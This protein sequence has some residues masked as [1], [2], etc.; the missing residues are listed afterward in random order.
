MASRL[1]R[2]SLEDLDFLPPLKRARVAR[3]SFW[4]SSWLTSFLGSLR[5]PRPR[6]SPRPAWLPA[7]LTSTFLTR[8][9]FRLPSSPVVFFFST[10]NSILPTTVGPDSF[11]ARAR[12]TSDSAGLAGALASGS[13]FAAG[14][15]SAGLAAGFS[16]AGVSSFLAVFLAGFLGFNASK[17]TVPTTLGP[18]WVGVASSAAAAGFAASDAGAAS[19]LAAGAGASAGDSSFAGVA[20]G[21]GA[22]WVRFTTGAASL[23]RNWLKSISGSSSSFFTSRFRALASVMLSRSW[24]PVALRWAFCLVSLSPWKLDFTSA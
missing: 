7:L 13:A 24:M 4:M 16:S 22:G 14:C 20:S 10:G 19:S 6:W 8:T 21:A 9:R 12:T 17:S 2:R 3:I 23:L 5:R 15:S 1:R 18:S 11:S